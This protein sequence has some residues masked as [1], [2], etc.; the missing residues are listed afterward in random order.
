MGRL[1]ESS[2]ERRERDKRRRDKKQRPKTVDMW[3][4]RSMAG[5]GEGRTRSIGESFAVW[6]ERTRGP[7]SALS[8]SADWVEQRRGAGR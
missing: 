5:V 6:D 3:T 1:G 8:G 4:V 7:L 2:D